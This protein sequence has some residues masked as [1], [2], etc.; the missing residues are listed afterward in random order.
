MELAE[1][2]VSMK[3]AVL[4]GAGMILSEASHPAPDDARN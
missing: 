1:P 2:V 4:C 3:E